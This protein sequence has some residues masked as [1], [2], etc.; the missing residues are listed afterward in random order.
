MDMTALEIV[1]RYYDCF[2]RKDYAGMLALVH[3]EV[4]HEVN[5]GGTRDGKALFEEFVGE[6]E[7]AYA[8]QL[9]DMVLFTEPS[10][11]LVAAQFT[12][13]GIY[14]K[15][16]PDMPPAHGQ[17]YVLPAGAFLEVRDGLVSK[18]TTYYNLPLW[19][20]LVSQ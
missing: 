20:Q 13:N 1:H 8:E 5:Q 11:R 17:S 4:C 16:D 6:M 12:V 18:V 10:G 14:K 7:E 15:G 3:P 19:I 2:N 9:T